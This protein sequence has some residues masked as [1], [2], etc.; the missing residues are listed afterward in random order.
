MVENM[1]ERYEKEIVPDLLKKFGFKNKMQVPRLLKVS[2]NRG[3]GCAANDKKKIVAACDEISL[4][5]G[6]KAVVTLSKK[7]NANFKLRE[8]QPIGVKVTLRGKKM[9]D[10]IYRLFN[11]VMPRIKNFK[12]TNPNSF[13]DS[14]NYN[15]GIKEQIVFPEVPIE[16]IQRIAGMNITFVISTKNKNQSLELLKAFGMPFRKN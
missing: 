8:K 15:L 14:A 6:Q 9:Y 7:A 10:F 2:I 13:D 12:G 3:E 4:I 11:I 16:S 1:K 5:S